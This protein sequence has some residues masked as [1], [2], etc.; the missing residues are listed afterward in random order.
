MKFTVKKSNFSKA[1]GQVARVV[2]TRATLPVLSNVLINADKELI[3]LSATDLE[4]A[5]TAKTT[6]EIE[7]SGL[8]TVSARLLSDFISN[9]TDDT[10]DFE[11]SDNNTLKLKSNHFKANIPG[12]SAEEFPTVPEIAKDYLCKLKNDDLLDSIKKVLISTANDETRPV[13]AGIYFQ[14]EGKIL[15]LA[16][17]DS[18]RLAEKKIELEEA[19]ESKKFIVPSRT[20]AEVLRLISGAENTEYITVYPTD[21]QIAFK[22][23][24]TEVVSRL[25]EGAFPNY[26]QIIP[27]S[28][29]YKI[30]V[31]Y[32][33]LVSAVKMTSIFAKIGTNNIKLKLQDKELIISSMASQAGDAES[34]IPAESDGKEIQIAFNSRYVLDV[35]QVLGQGKIIFELND[36]MSAGVIK[37]EKDSG[38]TYIVMP[39]KIDE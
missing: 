8:I 29:K 1:L 16:A 15:T 21:N 22:I 2:G 30:A 32:N 25:I 28:S 33:E 9:N 11:L 7:K 3:K 24:E 31:D 6:G 39:L 36:E 14:F 38:Y 35:L 37:A 20:M 10:I 27:I 23:G 34:K 17:T 13:L 19:V 26:V 12:I 5:I 4:V 18:F